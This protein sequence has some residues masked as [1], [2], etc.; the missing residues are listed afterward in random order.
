MPCVR[1]AEADQRGGAPE[2]VGT[3]LR[4]RPRSTH[5][6]VAQH[7]PPEHPIHVRLAKVQHLYSAIG[8]PEKPHDATVLQWVRRVH[9]NITTPGGLNADAP[10]KARRCTLCDA[11]SGSGTLTIRC[12]RTGPWCWMSRQEPVR[13]CTRRLVGVRRWCCELGRLPAA[14][15][16]NVWRWKQA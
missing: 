16:R 9:F 7:I 8:S 15:V 13:W 10:E 11:C 3:Y 14:T 5:A 2:S 12:G 1:A 6:K 4:L